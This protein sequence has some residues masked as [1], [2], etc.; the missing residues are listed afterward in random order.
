MQ[1]NS[2]IAA[3]CTGF[4]GAISVLR[5]S[6][7]NALKI[8]SKIFKPLKDGFSIEKDAKANRIY[9][10]FIVDNSGNEI[11]RVVLSVYLSPH[12]YTG[13]NIVEIS[14]HASSYVQREILSLLIKNGAELAKPGEFTRRAFQNK[15]MDLSQAEA[16]ADLIASKSKAEHDIAVNQMRGGITQEIKRLRDLLL[17]FTSLMELELD[18]S[19]EDVEFADRSQFKSILTETENYLS[20]LVNSFKFGNAIK[21]GI[22]VAICGRPNAGKSTLL[23]AL[24]NDERAIVTDIPGTTRDVL[25]DFFVVDGITYRLIDTAGIRETDDK[26]E[27]IG[28]DRAKNAMLKADIILAVLDSQDDVQK[29]FS[30]IIPSECFGKKIIAVINKTDLT[31]CKTAINF[32]ENVNIVKISAKQKTGLD[33][34]IKIISQYGAENL[35]YEGVILTNIRHYEIFSQALE[36]IKRAESALNSGLSGEFVSQDIREALRCFAEIT[37]DEITTDEVLGNIFKNFCIGK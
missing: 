22:P 2:T 33:D 16:V 8:V 21:N 31:D 10:G 37:G 23:N 32:P 20:R 28:I 36:A 34:L 17:K 12:S 26:I 9:N 27:K 11:D 3:I 25:E 13:E 6:G 29:Q 35:N 4:G 19:E 24:L 30:E 5:I 18:F 1:N 14:C 15:K 7:N